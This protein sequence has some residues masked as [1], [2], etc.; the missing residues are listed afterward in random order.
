MHKIIK[1]S[2]YHGIQSM[3]QRHILVIITFDERSI[4]LLELKDPCD[5]FVDNLGFNINQIFPILELSLLKRSNCYSC[6][7]RV[8]IYI[9]CNTELELSLP[10][11]CVG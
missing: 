8:E 5:S 6:Q 4:L 9:F 11:A 10:N 7:P 2:T 1:E 3:R